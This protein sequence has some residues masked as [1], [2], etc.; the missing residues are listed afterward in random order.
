VLAPE[1]DLAPEH[2]VVECMVTLAPELPGAESLIDELRV[3][4]VAVAAGHTGA[5][6]AAPARALDR[7]IGPGDPP[8]PR[9]APVPSP[10]ARYHRRGAR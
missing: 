5:D 6:H 8:V 1:D 10:R 4:G 7:G 9:Y 3:A 2:V